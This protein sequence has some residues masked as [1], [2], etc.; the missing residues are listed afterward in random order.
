[1]KGSVGKG[2]I[3]NAVDSLFVLGP[4]K[5]ALKLEKGPKRKRERAQIKG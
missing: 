5:E 1:M 2:Q 3:K 4:T